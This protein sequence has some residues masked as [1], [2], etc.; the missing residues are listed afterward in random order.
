MKF[1]GKGGKVKVKGGGKSKH[2]INVDISS[3]DDEA[4]PSKKKPKLIEIL[5]EVKCLRKDVSSI[6][7]LSK[8]MNLPPGLYNKLD[9]TFKC[10]ICHSSPFKLPV[11][12]GRCCRNIIGCSSC[13]D[14]WFKEESS[15]PL[16]RSDRA[17][18]DT[19]IINGL[20]EFILSITPLF[21]SS[22]ASMEPTPGGA[23]RSF[24][25]SPPR[26]QLDPFD[27]DTDFV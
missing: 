4:M 12:F 26:R 5:N 3:S 21:N 16:C 9:E 6:M 1:G 19:C 17:L 7:K 23:S 25:P 22:E 10:N 20:D 27:S 2:I 18:P 11:I 15:C 13:V 8:G 14:R 24:V